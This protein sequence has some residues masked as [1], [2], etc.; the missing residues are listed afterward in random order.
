[1][2]RCPHCN[3]PTISRMDKFLMGSAR[4]KQCSNCNGDWSISWMS[5]LWILVFIT[6]TLMTHDY[7]LILLGALVNL[8]GSMF[9]TPIVKVDNGR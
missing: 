2:Y 7:L 5:M 6:I 4:T 3:E 1:M 9:F 8:I